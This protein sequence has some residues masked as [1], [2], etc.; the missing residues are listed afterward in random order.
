M[1]LP[2]RRGVAQAVTYAGDTFADM[3]MIWAASVMATAC[4][5][6]APRD[7]ASEPAVGAAAEVPAHY[8]PLLTEGTR[9]EYEWKWR[10]DP[11][12]A[13]GAMPAFTTV[14]LACT[15]GPVKVVEDA[16]A[17]VARLAALECAMTP[18]PDDD[19][20]RPLLATQWMATADGLRAVADVED[21]AG[22]RAAMAEG[23]PT[24]PARPAATAGDVAEKVFA[25]GNGW[26]AES[27]S[28]EGYGYR[29]RRC[30]EP[31][32]GLVSWV[33]EGRNG[34]SEET[35]TRVK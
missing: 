9:L 6:K 32:R 19:G 13:E 30:F 27:S 12:D 26:C 11:H 33:V 2:S 5:S 4:S 3:R 14:A 8:A 31:G 16:G 15:V 34:P 7:G 20:L 17:E 22:V 21:L 28:T 23:P 1:L 18:S 24:V 25:Q 10:V 29:D 35:Y